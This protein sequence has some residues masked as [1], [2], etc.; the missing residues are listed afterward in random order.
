MAFEEWKFSIE[1]LRRPEREALL[2]EVGGQL[3]KQTLGEGFSDEELA[4]TIVDTF[5]MDYDVEDGLDDESKR[6]QAEYSYDALA[7]AAKW[8]DSAFPKIVLSSHRYAAALCCTSAT[9]EADVVLPWKAFVLSIPNELIPSS[10]G[11]AW[12]QQIRLYEYLGMY[13]LEIIDD[14]GAPIVS[15]SER[16]QD[17]LFSDDAAVVSESAVDGEIVESEEEAEPLT[18]RVCNACTRLLVGALY[19]L[20][21][22]NNFRDREGVYT[23]R[24]EVRRSGPPRHRVVVVGR[25]IDVDMRPALRQFFTGDRSSIPAFQTQVRGHYKRQVIG[26]GRS[27]RKVIWLMPYW[28]GPKAAPILTRPIRLGGEGA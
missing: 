17:L 9:S 22:T 10:M 3:W 26:V 6:L 27:G 28:R 13:H 23:S 16:I 12:V 14:M 7:F 1:D 24:G 18:K 4:R 20:Q 2:L 25:P 21:H 15:R 19:T 8:A 5:Q 11:G